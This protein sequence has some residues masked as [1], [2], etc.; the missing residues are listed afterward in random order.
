MKN[1]KRL[2]DCTLFRKNLSK[3][4]I[5][6]A[7]TVF[8][9]YLTM[10]LP[11]MMNITS[12]PG[13]P[14]GMFE[15]DIF[16]FLKYIIIESRYYAE[17]LA[18]LMAVM[19]FL[20]LQK[21]RSVSFFHSLPI[22]REG[23]FITNVVSAFVTMLIPNVI[24]A[25]VMVIQIKVMGCFVLTEVLGWVLIICV[26]EL[27]F[28]SLAVFSMIICGNEIAAV[29]TYAVIIYAPALIFNFVDNILEKITFGYQMGG[30][31]YKLSSFSPQYIFN[32]VQL[33]VW[34]KRDNGEIFICHEYSGLFPTLV[35][36]IL[37]SAAVF[38]VSL[39]LYRRRRSESAGD[40]TVF[41]WFT[42][43]ADFVISL[44]FALLTV[45]LAVR[46]FA[47]DIFALYSSELVIFMIAGL[48][49]SGVIGYVLIKVIIKKELSSIRKNLIPSLII[50]VCMV[51][52][53]LGIKAYSGMLEC[54]TPAEDDV[55]QVYFSFS[56][57]SADDT[58]DPEKQ[59]VA[60]LTDR[61]LI[62]EI[63]EINKKAAAGKENWLKNNSSKGSEKI[64]FFYTL[65]DTVNTEFE[66]DVPESLERWYE[67][68]CEGGLYEDCRRLYEE[69]LVDLVL[70]GRD[71]N[72]V[73]INSTDSYSFCSVDMQSDV[74]ALINALDEDAKAGR[75]DYLTARN[76]HPDNMASGGMKAADDSGAV[77]SE[78]FVCFFDRMDNE[79]I[80]QE[81]SIGAEN[82]ANI[83]FNEGCTS[84]M[85]VYNKLCG[86]CGMGIDIVD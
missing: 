19:L 55:S 76:I 61:R 52:V 48:A 5:I 63:I 81:G 24:I 68:S 51:V 71:Y 21:S 18:G 20:Y 74:D 82:I 26:E 17:I 43:V 53:G 8:L 66:M 65:K 10:V 46:G 23:L 22:S 44:V 33:K 42:P 86:R 9:M 75:L 12:Q 57:V 78:S 54:Y 38:G 49:V 35:I 2:F 28:F 11:W 6:S 50:M 36:V 34:H 56:S 13:D 7:V 73:N 32:N 84:T 25:A 59:Y 15:Y 58:V 72:F 29:I 67:L 16:S 1:K 31:P 14:D 64:I 85:K 3:T 69:N 70:N 30:S 37:I 77:P 79:Q 41:K 83:Y 39:M 27:F 62:S 40:M 4:W 60:M 80:Q 47:G 45:S